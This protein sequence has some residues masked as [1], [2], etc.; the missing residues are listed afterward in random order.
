ME[1]IFVAVDFKKKS[2]VLIDYAATLAEKFASKVW[3]V[4]IAAPE[5]DFVGYTPGPQYIRDSRAEELREEHRVLQDLS[6]VLDDMGIESEAL[7]IQGPTVEM[8]LEEADKL[9]ADLIICGNHHHSFLHNAFIGSTAN[10]LFRKSKIP[11][12]AI[13][14]SDGDDD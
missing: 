9:H 8:I 10:E 4:H 13:P 6:A 1:N 12:L 14:V 3:I 7:L 5:P 2:T 11:F